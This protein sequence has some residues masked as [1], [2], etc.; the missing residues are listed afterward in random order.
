[1][2]NRSAG[3]PEKIAKNRHFFD[4][5]TAETFPWKWYNKG[6]EKQSKA[7]LP[8]PPQEVLIKTI[9]QLNQQID[10]LTQ[11]IK[12][13]Q[14][15][16]QEL[17][18]ENANLREQ[19]TYLIKQLFAPKTEK[20][21]Q[22]E[23]QRSIFDEAE[24]EADIEATAKTAGTAEGGADGGE[25]TIT[26]K[27][28]KKS[29]HKEMM[30]DLE[31]REQVI[32]LPESEK[33][34]SVCGSPLELIGREI[35]RDE[36][37]VIP[38]K[39]IRNKLYRN[40]YGCPECKKE[41]DEANII[42]APAPAALISKSYVT[43]SMAAFVMYNKY[44]MSMPLY[45][46]EKDWNQ[47]GAIVNR[48]TLA[49]WCIICGIDYILPVVDR[50]HEELMK[51]DIIY[52]DESPIQVL[53]EEG[54]K[55]SQV[56]YIWV[57]CSG[58][59]EEEP[60][61]VIFSYKPT[62]AGAN[63]VELLKDFRGHYL[64][65]DG[66]QGYNL[67]KGLIRCACL[68]HIRR[69]FVDAIPRKNGAPMP[70]S[71]AMEGKEFCDRLFLLERRFAALTPEERKEK[72]LEY[73]K[74]VLEAFWLWLERQRPTSGSRLD[75]AVTYALNQRRFMEN[76]LLDGRIE[77]SNNTSEN[78]IRPY[79]IGRRNWLFANTS[80]GAV[81]SAAIYSLIE[82]ARAN[83]LRVRPYLQ[84]VLEYMRDHKDGSE[85]IDDIL[86]W[87]AAMQEKFGRAARKGL[88]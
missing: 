81:A 47:L 15:T 26:Y 82:T 32:D 6:M 21:K 75:K 49:N 29:T 34:C 3:N 74:P 45:R 20:S 67:L 83:N 53:H 35:V 60:P 41:T 25:I 28:K 27:R 54:R 86:P 38:P 46:Q 43:P 24:E 37:E 16:I 78:S 42:K 77:I 9:E 71:R 70:G 65:C 4:V 64:V 52:C 50:M 18:T 13:L 8:A 76:Y 62:R 85:R 59:K 39:V 63:A 87:S 51:R 12:Q 11:T 14:E 2:H 72:R 88:R 36:L 19:N 23:G 1:M 80:N 68:A 17:R 10:K 57:T 48:T 69:K 44:F 33:V 22:I 79:A 56:S 58:K 31:E 5:Q 61:I 66:Y 40:V 30:G 84:E 73:E 7:E 55:A